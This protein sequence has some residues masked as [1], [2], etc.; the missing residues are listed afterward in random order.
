M[1]VQLPDPHGGQK[2]IK[3]VVYL[4]EKHKAEEFHIASL[5]IFEASGKHTRLLKMFPLG[6]IINNFSD[7]LDF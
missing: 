5:K 6:E 2:E 3:E 1:Y 4:S 7:F